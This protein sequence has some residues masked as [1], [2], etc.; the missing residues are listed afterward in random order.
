ML[1]CCVDRRRW[2]AGVALGT[3]A[4]AGTALAEPTLER[5]VIGT[6]PS[7]AP[8]EV[9]TVA[10]R[11]ETGFGPGERPAVAVI[12]GVQAHHRIGVRVAEAMGQLLVD[13]HADAL[14]G[15][16]LYII[17]RVN[18]DGLTRFT[19]GAPKSL[20]ARAPEPRDADR[21]RRVDEDPPNDLNGDGLITMM[22]IP[23]PNTA[24]GLEPT[25]LIDAGDP[26]IVREPGDNEGPTHGLLIEGVDDDGDGHLNEDGWGGASGGGIDLDKHFPTQWPE[27][28]DGA[29]R[30]PLDRPEALALVEWLQ[31]RGNVAA[32]IVL[33]PHDTIVS[34][35]PTGRF[36]PSGRV[37]EGIEEDD[38]GA[39]QLASESFK[40]ITGIKKTEPGPDRAGSLVQWCYADLGVYAFGTPVWVRPDLV[41]ED[42]T[43]ADAES[44]DGAEAEDGGPTAEQLE[45]ADRADMAER[46]VGQMFIDFLYMTAAEQAGVLAD[47]QTMSETEAADVMQRFAALPADIRARLTA[48]QTGG[49][50][51]GPSEDLLASI[52]ASAGVGDTG[53]KGGAGGDTA[54]AKWLAWIDERDAGGFV[55]WQPFD[56]PQLGEVE[57]GGFVP[58]V[59]V[60][61]PP[62]F[63]D[64]LAAQQ[65]A[66]AAAVLDMLPSLELDEPTVE[67]VG[68]GIWRVGVTLRNTGTLP[69]KSAI[70]VKSRRLAGIVCVIDP[71]QDLDT[72]KI[73]SGPRAIRFAAIDGRGASE[74]AE[75]LVIAG[76]G[77]TVD[78]EVRTPQ[79]G[80]VRF[81]LTM[82][83]E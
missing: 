41:E 42:E 76:D 14:A 55:D 52:G 79:F 47:M 60:N 36:G 59:R 77:D 71:D 63:E 48:T 38:A 61:P 24:Y 12:A 28:A 78:L 81:E 11:D 68:G 35:P 82:E 32:V 10:D 43:E 56:H 74:R 33:G 29:G 62:E 34:T 3:A 17:P 51:P 58:G 27:H 18:P 9:W 53:A 83:D 45:A 64:K 40:E 22:R 65:A 57:I 7:G 5:E 26:R 20:S 31:S 25:H 13:K 46:G 70:G 21:D 54:E 75:W 6:S 67:R 2:R 8:I 16:T 15:R 30:F 69:T 50:D 49:E 1:R 4:L 23:A 80:K 66:F 37:P 19:S 44:E 73:I 39:Y 72:P